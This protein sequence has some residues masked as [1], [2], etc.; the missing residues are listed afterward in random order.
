[1]AAAR[2]HGTRKGCHYYETDSL[3][4]F[5]P[6]CERE[7]QA[8]EVIFHHFEGHLLV[9]LIQFFLGGDCH[10]DDKGLEQFEDG[11]GIAAKALVDFALTRVVDHMRLVFDV[12]AANIE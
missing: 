8:T 7:H 3:G 9:E 6:N 11:G 10:S 12:D 1:M 5:A 4:F 2:D